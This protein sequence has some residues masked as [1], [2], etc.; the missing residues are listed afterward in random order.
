MKAILLILA[1]LVAVSFAARPCSAPW[2]LTFRASRHDQ[3]DTYYRRYYTEYDRPNQRVVMFE[4]SFTG[5][6]REL[7]EFLFLHYID[8]GFEY[9]F[10]L[11][12]CTR[13]R[14]GPFRPFEVPYNSTYEGS[15]QVGGPGEDLTVDIWSDRIPT[16]RENW[17][18]QFSLRNCYPVSQFLVDTQ[19]FNRTSISHFFDVVQGIVNP[20]DFDVPTEC[21]RL[22]TYSAM[23]DQAR[24]VR[25]LYTGTLDF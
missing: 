22:T 17:L 4:E 16:R 20:N 7:R 5:G 21:A 12:N 19:N 11:K 6:T 1:A 25:S 3:G 15:F 18:G 8:T 23:P 24:K 10:K 14:T 9:D 13:F 2:E